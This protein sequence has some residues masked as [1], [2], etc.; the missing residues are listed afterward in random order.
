MAISAIDPFG[1][2][3]LKPTAAAVR[4]SEH[5]TVNKQAM[6]LYVDLC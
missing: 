6:A 2:L 5:F 4:Q 1:S 3:L